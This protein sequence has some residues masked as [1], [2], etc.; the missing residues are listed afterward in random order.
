MNLAALESI[1]RALKGI[2]AHIE[3]AIVDLKKQPS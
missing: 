3:R 2:L 1:R